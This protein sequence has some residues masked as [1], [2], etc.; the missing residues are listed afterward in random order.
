VASRF[1]LRIISSRPASQ[2]QSSAR[3]LC[4][5]PKPP[6]PLRLIRSSDHRSVISPPARCSLFLAAP[7]RRRLFCLAGRVQS[8]LYNALLAG[9]GGLGDK[10]SLVR[11][12]R[13]KPRPSPS[14]PDAGG[15]GEAA[16]LRL[17]PSPSRPHRRDPLPTSARLPWP[18][19]GPALVRCGWTWEP[20]IC[21]P[22]A[23]RRCYQFYSRRELA[24]LM[25]HRCHARR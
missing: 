8:V 17:M 21:G 13:A 24:C 5:L 12:A 2:S 4:P 15:T 20:P 23:R 14:A 1:V 6:K 18:S 16:L 3:G 10:L 25:A 11:R 19:L 9:T 22:A 7:S